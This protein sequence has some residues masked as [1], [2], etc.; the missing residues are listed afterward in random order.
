ML[1]PESIADCIELLDRQLN[2]VKQQSTDGNVRIKS[3]DI[4]V[5]GSFSRMY[6]V[7]LKT[8]LHNHSVFY[9]YMNQY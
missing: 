6:Q 2:D 1:N 5:E 9:T 8:Q 4:F 3:N 7:F